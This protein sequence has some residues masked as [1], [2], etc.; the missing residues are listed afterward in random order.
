ML[1]ERRKEAHTRHLE[2][3]RQRAYHYYRS[4]PDPREISHAQSVLKRGID[5]DW[6]T[7]VQ[8]YPEV[9]EYFFSLVELTLPQED[10]P[11]VKDPPLS[12]LT[13]SRKM[14]RRHPPEPI[15][16]GPFYPPALEAL[17]PRHTITPP[18]PPPTQRLGRRTPGPPAPPGPPAMPR[19]DRRSVRPPPPPSSYYAG[20]NHGSFY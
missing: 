11:S 5:E 20:P 17:P 19:A 13:G 15:A 1:S 16:P 9:L 6:Q 3:I 2:E 7:S 8:R 12:A 14:A 18:M 4:E 10:E